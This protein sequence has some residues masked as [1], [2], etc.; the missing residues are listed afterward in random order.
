MK[1]FLDNWYKK[2]FDELKETK[3]LRV[4]SP[5]ISEQIIRKIQSQFDFNNFELI[6]RFNLHEFASNVSSFDGLR[7]AVENGAKIWGIKDLHS[8]VY[9]FDNRAAIITSANLTNGGLIHNY[10]CGLYTIDDHILC[11]LDHYFENLKS[12]GGEILTIKKCEQWQKE[13]NQVE[14]QNSKISSLPDYGSTK[15]IIDK[16]KFYYV[17]FFGT[18]KNRMNSEF[19]VRD[20]I[21]RA[22]CHY[23]CGFSIKKPPK[24]F[25][26]GDII[27]MARMTKKPNDYAIFGRAEAVKFVEGRDHATPNEKE[28]REWKKEWPIYLG[29]ENPVFIDGKLGDCILLYDLI[30]ALDYESFPTTKKRVQNGEININ[31]RKSL[32]QQPYIELTDKAVEWLEPKFNRVLET[33][34]RVPKSYIN[35]LPKSDIDWTT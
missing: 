25:K 1:L 8:K 35:S 5:F 31:P 32:S 11:E 22:L 3:Y 19:K 13:L 16:S 9:L 18:D 24:Q 6:T 2:L 34:G 15:T 26:D 12:L 23:A 29:V 33:I 21:E 30:K 4:I 14:P 7:F 27:Y 20:E 10:E 28:Q 17:K